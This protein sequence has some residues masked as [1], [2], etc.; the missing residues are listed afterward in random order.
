MLDIDK[1]VQWKTAEDG[2]PDNPL[3]ALTMALTSTSKDMSESKLDASLYGII[4]GWD[5]SSYK[6]L[7]EKHGWSDRVVATQKLLHQ[8]YIKAWQLLTELGIK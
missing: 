4:V 3:Q 5:E 1:D 6:E 2:Y 7:K 8:N